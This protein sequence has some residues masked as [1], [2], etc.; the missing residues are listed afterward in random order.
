[1][2]SNTIALS[3]LLAAAALA[4]PALR[5]DEHTCPLHAK[6][7]A[8]KERQA[9]VDE[10][11]DA[12]MGFSHDRTTHRFRLTADGGEIRVTAGDAKDKASVDAIRTHL[13]KVAADFSSGDFEMPHAIHATVPPGVLAM[14][15]GKSEI[16]YVYEPVEKGGRV[17]IRTKPAALRAAVHE[18][19]RFQ[20]EDHRTGDPTE[21]AS[22]SSP[23]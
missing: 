15:D 5:A 13:A 4:A 9:K 23:R 2:K 17:V 19:L 22:A 6:H 7:M 21:V 8:E 3:A 16:A 20:I 1:M 10:R 11:G 12:V 14:K 18:F